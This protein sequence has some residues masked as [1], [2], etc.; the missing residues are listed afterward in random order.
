MTRLNPGRWTALILVLSFA[1]IAAAQTAEGPD[2]PHRPAPMDAEEGASQL[3]AAN[4]NAVRMNR[5][6]RI[7]LHVADLPIAEVLRM[8]SSETRR[9]I[10][11][12]NKVE[13]VVTANLY[14]VTL[15]QALAAILR[16]NRL[17]YRESDDFIY[18]YTQEEMSEITAAERR[19]VS[20]VFRLRYINAADAKA[21]LEPLLGP[22]GKIAVT[23]PS[24]SGLFSG[25]GPGGS[26]AASGGGGGGGQSSAMTTGGN[27]LGGGDAIVVTDDSDR[28]RRM[29]EVLREVDV[30]PRQVL[31]EATILRASLN[32]D[33]ALGIDFTTLGGVDFS[34]VGSTSAAVQNIVTGDLPTEAL[35]KTTLTTRTDFA[36]NVPPGGLTF[37]IIKNNVGMFIRALEDVADTSVIAN[38]K[39]LAL[40]KQRGEVIVGRRDGY[41]TT[42]VTD[43]AAIQTVEFLE[44]GTQL[45]FRPFILDDATVRMEIHPKDSIGGL[46]PAN[47]PFEQT[48]EV[49]S[50]ILVRDGHTVVI[51]GLFRE[52]TTAN[53]S[54]LPL[55]GNIPVAGALFRSSADSSI[56]E[57]VIILLTVRI[58]KGEPE[59]S[60]GEM[61]ADQVE[62]YRIGNRQ[63]LLPTGRERLAQAHYRWALEHLAAG[64]LSQAEWDARM[65]VHNSP[66]FVPALELIETL[67]RKRQWDEDAS[68]VRSHVRRLI[69]PERDLAMPPFG[70]PAPPFVVPGESDE[71]GFDADDGGDASHGGDANDAVMPIRPPAASQGA[72]P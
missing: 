56:R 29:A 57:E 11:A 65:A 18:V 54:Q 19:V 22:A 38:P 24:Q 43:T 58:V 20:Q 17:A 33:N 8:L 52:V 28:V 21:L 9:N 47:L 71:G 16:M 7:E 68:A 59:E 23:P 49:T 53:R 44:T 62:R 3:A 26:Q 2:A 36:G 64:R 72:A 55:L 46:T 40:N 37:G 5:A 41:T 48:T 66:K 34:Q 35:N 70:R 42:T 15:E 50:N 51:G 1:G 30:R 6:H 12:S 10:V 67:Q 25:S 14:D 61:L 60:E 45:I 39:V 63:G 27:D 32:E 13:G 4:V 31:I 69:A